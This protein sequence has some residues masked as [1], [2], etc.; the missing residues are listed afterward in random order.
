MSYPPSIVGNKQY[1]NM[2]NRDHF[3]KL[4]SDLPEER[5]Q[6][7]LAVINELSELPEDGA[8]E[9][10]YTINRLVRGLGSSRNSARLGFSLCLSEAV[11]LAMSMD[12]APMGLDDMHNYL[13]LLN[14]NLE[15]DSKKK[16]GKEERGIL[17]GKLFGLQALLS[18]PLFTK[19]FLHNDKITHFFSTFVEELISLSSTKNW[20]REPALFTLYQ[21]VERLIAHFT[22]EDIS[23]LFQVLDN[24]KLTLTNEGLALYLLVIH[25]SHKLKTADASKIQLKNPGWKL[26]DPLAKGNMPLLSRVLLDNEHIEDTED[27]DNKG[28]SKGTTWSPRLHFVWNILLK[29]LVQ[30]KTIEEE[31]EK[32]KNSKHV[33]KKRKKDNG[34]INYVQFHEFWQMVVDETYFN[35]KA[36]SERKYL[37]FLIFETTFPLL[38]TSDMVT[39]SLSQNFVRSLIN[40]CSD[41]K[42]HLNKI[43]LQV[44]EVIIHSCEQNSMRIVPTFNALAFGKNGSTNFDRLSKTK[45]L[46]RLTAIKTMTD[47]VLVNMFNLLSSSIDSNTDDKASIQFVLDN[48]LHLVRNHKQTIDVVLVKDQLL[49]K[50]VEYSFFANDNEV[51]HEL[52]KER[53]FSILSELNN[54]SQLGTEVSPQYIVVLKIQE[55][56]KSGKKLVSELDEELANVEKKSLEILKEIGS[57]KEKSYLAGL[58]SLFAT[59]LLQLYTGD[60]ESVG[61]LGELQDIYDK[62]NQESEKQLSSVTEILLSLLAQKKALLKKASIAVW[63]QMVPYVTQEELNLLLDILL[64]REN[65]EGF[66]HLF[67][68]VDEYEVD[69]EEDELA[70]SKEDEDDEDEDEDEDDDS[71]DESNESG[72]DNVAVAKIDKETTSALAKALDLPEDIIKDN[73]EVDVDRLEEPSEDESMDDESMDDESMDDEQMMELDDQLSEIFKRRKDALSQIPTGNKRK[74]EVKESRENVIAFKHRVVDLLGIYIK[75]VEKL[76]LQDSNDGDIV[77]EKVGYLLTFPIPI[78]KCI[79]QTL[80]RALA[81]KL[82]KLLKGKVFKIRINKLSLDTV[83]I[84]EDFQRIHQDFLF[85]K[86]GQ[87]SNIYYNLCSSTSLFFSKVLIEN[88]DYK[89]GM[90]ENLVDTY[91]STIKEWLKESKFP[92]TIFL[93]FVN[94]LAAKKQANKAIE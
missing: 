38:E 78:I 12:N 89:Q 51:L 9:W 62:V 54:N 15:N 56:L 24:H 72:E 74:N 39:D 93:D 14:S 55:G 73:G 30:T 21:T 64:A 48:M 43:A 85:A 65:K 52:S 17:F 13:E 60:S 61:T 33:S 63:E 77:S 36:S 49:D 2:I 80:D 3:Y 58:G 81:D 44:V 84:L 57:S 69:D 88:A 87:Y 35:D 10:Q 18:D 46:D 92:H 41:K 32:N 28:K 66:A 4:A 59:C 53:L 42:R 67:E 50:L 90:F 27:Q 22:N 31:E 23:N 1:Y 71:S 40:Q 11:N 37:G 76:V 75:Y 94:W 86:S 45:L 47:D 16:K 6:A 79:R 83:T 5:L 19:A 7:A 68:G 20:I 70:E 25:Q 34:V 26:N 29:L 91:S 8:S 82:S